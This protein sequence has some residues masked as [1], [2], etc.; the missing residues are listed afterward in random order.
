MYLFPS[1]RQYEPIQMNYID[2]LIQLF[3]NNIKFT[4]Y[5][6]IYIVKLKHLNNDLILT[7]NFPKI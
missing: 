4:N 1:L 6:T 3:F 5:N 2:L 7:K